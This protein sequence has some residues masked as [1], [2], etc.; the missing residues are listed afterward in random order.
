M[1]VHGAPHAKDR[2]KNVSFA[3]KNQINPKA[4]E[5]CTTKKVHQYQ[6]IIGVIRAIR[7]V[8]IFCCKHRDTLPA[9]LLEK[10]KQIV[11]QSSE[12]AAHVF[13]Q[14]ERMRR[15]HHRCLGCVC[16]VVEC[17]DKHE[18]TLENICIKLSKIQ[19]MLKRLTRVHPG[20]KEGQILR[21]SMDMRAWKPSSSVLVND[22]V[23]VALPLDCQ[24]DVRTFAPPL[25]T[26]QC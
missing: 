11:S 26:E 18:V 21:W 14:I 25:T 10:V 24:E 7:Q 12:K 17:N 22:N 23:H 8:S 6:E 16:K 4:C 15:K 3:Q 20:C 19:C 2:N 13:K 1:K 5:K 9:H